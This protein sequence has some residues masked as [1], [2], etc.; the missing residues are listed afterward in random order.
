MHAGV[1]EMN[2]CRTHG[3]TTGTDRVTRVQWDMHK[4]AALSPDGMESP[5]AQL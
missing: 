1:R 4:G 2:A 3:G 5:E